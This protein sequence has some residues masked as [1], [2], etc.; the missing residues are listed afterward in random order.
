MCLIKYVLNCEENFSFFILLY[1]LSDI[2][3]N[4]NRRVYCYCDYVQNLSLR[5]ESRRPGFE[6][7]VDIRGGG[8]QLAG[9]M[10]MTACIRRKYHSCS[11]NVRHL[12]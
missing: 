3:I 10:A 2:R 7:R 5:E 12:P 9:Y 4:C 8:A 6:T 1:G 11:Q